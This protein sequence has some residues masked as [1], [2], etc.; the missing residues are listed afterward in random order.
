MKIL[1]IVALLVTSN[2]A[3]ADDFGV[4]PMGADIPDS[5]SQSTNKKKKKKNQMG[6]GIVDLNQDDSAMQKLKGDQ[7]DTFALPGARGEVK[8]SEKFNEILSHDQTPGKTGE[9]TSYQPFRRTDYLKVLNR[10]GKTGLSLR[11]FKDDFEY[12]DAQGIFQRTFENDSG[13]LKG[14]MVQFQLKRYLKRSS[15]DLS[16]VA[17]A[18]FAYAE[19]KGFFE[20]ATERSDALFRFYM[21]PVD[22]GLSLGIPMGQYF[23]LSIEGGASAMGLIQNR[24][25]L[26]RASKDKERRQVSPGYYAGISSRINLSS[27]F[28]RQSY[29]L[30][31]E[32]D[33]TNIYLD[34]NVR[35]QE[36]S[37]FQ[38]DFEISG[39]SFG[40]GFT[41]EYL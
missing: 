26:A 31:I 20:G 33:L 14:G 9:A 23:K 18:G 10:E 7:K 22:L 16:Y 38:N 25:D 36:Y 12:T 8:K 19:G 41:F 28:K 32:S 15:I 4:I 39:Q 11:Y 24:N 27:I 37:N 21:I 17:N 1:L 29:Q 3:L 6:A 34:L 35:H 40:A 13:S 2:F 30:F 5:L